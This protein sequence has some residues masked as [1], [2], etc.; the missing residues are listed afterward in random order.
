MR[1]KK[2]VASIVVT[3]IM[4]ALVLI[5][6]GIV[7][8]VISNLIIKSTGQIDVSRICLG[9]T[10]QPTAT[11]CTGTGCVVTL[12]RTGT[13]TS[14]IGGV[15]LVLKNAS[16]NSQPIDTTEDGLDCAGNIPG[17]V[18]TRCTVSSVSMSPLVPTDANR[19]E[20][21]VYIMDDQGA[22]RLCQQTTS[23]NF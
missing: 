14:P 2:G 19:V 4:V 18:P 15:M 5:A 7:W 23:F 8:A 13:E 6:I 10:V 1:N 16:S 3:V 11:S 20:A 17:L 9:I 21:T 22:R 12:E